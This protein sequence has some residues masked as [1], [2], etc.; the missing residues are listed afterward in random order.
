[1]ERFE[2]DKEVEEKVSQILQKVTQLPL[3]KILSYAVKGEEDAIQLYKFLSQKIEEPHAKMK[4]EQFVRI[5][6]KHKE[7][8]LK[9]FE[10]L[11]P[12][13]KSNDDYLN[14][15]KAAISSEKL[16]EKMYLFIAQALEREYADIFTS[17]AGD[18]KQHYDFLVNQYLFYKRAKAEEDMHKMMDKLLRGE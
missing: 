18:E 6:S 10:E 11:F 15:L 2:I 7:E 13:I 1:M 17:L 3:E 5:E 9:V 8:I 14:I 12:G 16:A 4:F